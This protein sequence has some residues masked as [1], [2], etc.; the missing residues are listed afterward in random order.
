MGRSSSA[1]A[2]PPAR[3]N[4]SLVCHRFGFAPWGRFTADFA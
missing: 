2:G 4:D 1:A 3:F